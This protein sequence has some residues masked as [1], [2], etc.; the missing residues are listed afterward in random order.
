MN[1]LTILG[2]T[3]AVLGV[4]VVVLVAVAAMVLGPEV[5]RA[6]AAQGQ[7]EAQHEESAQ[8]DSLPVKHRGSAP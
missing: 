3:L 6:I 4:L 8:S 2:L 1:L 5:R 7:E